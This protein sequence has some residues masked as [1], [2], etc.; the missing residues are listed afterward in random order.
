MKLFPAIDLRGGQVVRL[1]QG[2][3]DRMTVYGADP[4]A[5]AA[6]FRQAGASC[7]HLVDLDGARDGAPAN[8]PAI[9]A[10][11]RQ[12]GLYIEVGGGIRT[13]Q[14]IEEYLALGVGRCILGSVAVTDF[15][16]TARMLREYGGKLAVGVDLKDGRAAIHGWR[17]TSGMD[18]LA[19]CRRLADAGCTALIVTDIARDGAMQGTNLE[20][21]R[22]L[23]QELPGLALTASGGIRRMEELAALGAMGVDAAILGKSLYTGALN[24]AECVRRY[25]T[26][27]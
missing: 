19:F 3:Y 27:G 13:Q 4:A 9:Q 15:A 1:T 21:Y 12:G 24:L 23:R 7:L 17:E 6:A 10:I 14:R 20:L 2:D 18:G 22:R 26:K 11:A 16:F 5:Q 25:E 8:G